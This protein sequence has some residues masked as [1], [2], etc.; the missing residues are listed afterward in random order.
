[1]RHWGTFPDQPLT[2][3]QAK[4]D[5]LVPLKSSPVQVFSWYEC[6]S[7]QR[8]TF[9]RPRVW[10]VV[11]L[12]CGHCQLQWRGLTLDVPCRELELLPSQILLTL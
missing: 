10:G 2:D 7:C 1:M 11:T 8:V 6:P 3:V 5:A 4:V 9:L 12:T